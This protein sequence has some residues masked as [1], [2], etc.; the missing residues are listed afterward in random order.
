MKVHHGTAEDVF[1]CTPGHI[2][3]LLLM[4]ISDFIGS[5][6]LQTPWAE[7]PIVSGR[8]ASNLLVTLL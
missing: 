1:L 2:R 3:G 8:V 7:R 5:N 4:A 6:S